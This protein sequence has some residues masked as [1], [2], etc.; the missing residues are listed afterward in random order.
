MNSNVPSSAAKLLDF[1]GKA[2]TG[3]AGSAGYG[4]VVFHKESKIGKPLTEFTIDELLAAQ[5]VW[6]S[7][8]WSIKGKKVRGSAAGRYQIIR[9]T[10]RGL[11]VKLGLP[12]FTKF[13]ADTQ[14]RLGFE[15]LKQRGYAAFTSGQIS[16]GAFAL[17]LSQEWASMPVLSALQGAHRKVNRGESYYAGDGVNASQKDASELE[18][19]LAEIGGKSDAKPPPVTPVKPVEPV[20]VPSGEVSKSNSAGIIVAAATLIA[21]GF[22]WLVTQWEHIVQWVVSL[23]S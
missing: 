17:G 23:F 2:E 1:I 12:G 15:L 10:L 11:V 20:Y 9:A 6:A 7:T 18:A 19:I 13:S 14:D 22:T 4:V 8:G 21:G 16:V 5:K 3:I